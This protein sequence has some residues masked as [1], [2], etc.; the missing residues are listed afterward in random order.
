MMARPKFSNIN[1][2][3]HPEEGAMFVA[4]D[5]EGK[6][7]CGR[8]DVIVQDAGMPNTLEV[9]WQPINSVFDDMW[10]EDASHKDDLEMD[11][12][13]AKVLEFIREREPV[14]MSVIGDRFEN[15][16]VMGGR[17]KARDAV[18]KLARMGHV[19]VTKEKTSGRPR[20]VVRS[21]YDL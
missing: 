16:A 2:I 21:A 10:D 14:A 17:V 1:L 20:R 8:P 11:S 19:S 9:D 15:N 4:V 3:Q 6:L 5:R 12:F 18:E 7:W 13:S